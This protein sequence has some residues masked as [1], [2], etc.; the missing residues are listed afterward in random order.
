MYNIYFVPSFYAHTIN[1][2]LLLISIIILYKNYSKIKV[3]EP[4][5]LVILTLVFS[6]AVGIHGLSHL[7]LEK[8]YHYNPIK[9]IKNVIS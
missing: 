5:K 1:G 6:I 9:L 8:K 3:L 4:Y 2:L 7:G